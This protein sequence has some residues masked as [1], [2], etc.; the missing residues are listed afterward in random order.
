MNSEKLINE[1]YHNDEIRD[2]LKAVLSGSTFSEH[3]WEPDYF[4]YVE[5]DKLYVIGAYVSMSDQ[6]GAGFWA[7]TIDDSKVS[8][9]T[10][11]FSQGESTYWD[12]ISI[13]KMKYPK[14][15]DVVLD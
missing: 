10:M 14:L 4:G 1:I 5:S 3:A 13:A 9:K 11:Y 6:D 7:F 15:V 12:A 8:I 2:E